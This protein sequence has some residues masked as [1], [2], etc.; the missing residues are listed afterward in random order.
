MIESRRL[1]EIEMKRKDDV[2][3]QD[4]MLKKRM[5]KLKGRPTAT[6]GPYE[7]IK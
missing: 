4:E 5:E 3:K 2:I 6:L 7:L 1:L